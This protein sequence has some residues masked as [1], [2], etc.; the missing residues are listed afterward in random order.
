MLG[1]VVG[2]IFL[3]ALFAF[4]YYIRYHRK[5]GGGLTAHKE[6]F[7][8]TSESD[9]KPKDIVL[10]MIT[11]PKEDTEITY[12]ILWN[13]KPGKKYNY[14]VS[15]A[16]SATVATGEVTCPDS[17]LVKIKGIPIED[18]KVYDVVVGDTTVNVIF[19]PPQFILPLKLGDGDGIEMDTSVV[20]TSIEVL[21]SGVAVPLARCLIKIDPGD[22][23]LKCEAEFHGEIT[24]MAYNGPNAAN[25]Y[26]DRL[27]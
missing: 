10:A 23:G 17:G 7:G 6:V 8:S 21:S 24:I 20:P 18:G 1:A 11:S 4:L 15:E 26:V 19:Q 25:I 12:A 5:D 9:P 16:G 27:T 13:G 2:V 14:V 22:P 3:L